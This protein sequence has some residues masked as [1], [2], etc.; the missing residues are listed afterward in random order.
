MKPKI[1]HNYYDVEIIPPREFQEYVIRLSQTL[2]R[3][4]AP[5]KL[6][7]R[8]SIPHITL[9]HVPVRKRDMSEFL[10][11]AQTIAHGCTERTIACQLP[12]FGMA[13]GKAWV[14]LPT[15][16]PQWL[17]KL[18]ATVVEQTVG[19]FNYQNPKIKERIQ[20]TWNLSRFTGT[21]RRE[22]QRLLHAYGSV[23]VDQFWY[24]HV[25]LGVFRNAGQAKAGYAHLPKQRSSFRMN[26]IAVYELGENH[27]CQRKI[28]EFPF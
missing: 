7:R 19:F 12:T 26:R 15:S 27:S 20:K 4:G 25:T 8:S 28:A 17:K 10:R 11:V 22:R 5:W 16:K 24:P 23:M 6:G 9:F 3:Y 21:E 14:T 2:Y 18:H 13:D 1:Y